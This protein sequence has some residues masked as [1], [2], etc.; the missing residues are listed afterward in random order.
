MRIRRMTIEDVPILKLEEQWMYDRYVNYLD[1]NTGPAW[2]LENGEPL[3]A[4]GAAFE[5]PGACEAWFNLIKKTHTI[6]IIRTVKRY[7]EEQAKILNVKRM[8]AIV[9]KDNKKNIR[10][11]LALDF[12][13]EGIMRKKLPD[14]SDA[15]LFAR[16]F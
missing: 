8:Q 14:G 15:Y 16:I 3:C 9:R 5:W 11:L 12:K 1:C 6:S 7:I 13:I 4:F 10:F 2:I